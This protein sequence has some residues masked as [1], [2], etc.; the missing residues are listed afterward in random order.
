VFVRPNDAKQKA[1]EAKAKFSHADGDHL[2][3]L[4]VYH[5]YKGAPDDNKWCYDNFL[6]LRTLKS[7]DNVRDQLQKIMERMG[8]PLLSTDFSDQKVYYRNIRM[9]LAAGFFMQAAH[10]EKT[11]HYLTVK[12]NQVRRRRLRPLGTFFGPVF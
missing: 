3:L 1:D 12:D 2:T 10:L 7:A 4:N 9:A 8:L 11:G 5:A 6:N